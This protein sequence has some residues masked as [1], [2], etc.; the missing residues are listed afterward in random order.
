MG[1]REEGKDDVEA[2]KLK[3][4]KKKLAGFFLSFFLFPL[5]GCA[6]F[7]HDKSRF[8]FVLAYYTT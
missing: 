7:A 6:L 3:M 4:A 1:K 5:V 8:R 2:K